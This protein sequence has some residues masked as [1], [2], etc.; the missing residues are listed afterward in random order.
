LEQGW[1]TPPQLRPP[2]QLHPLPC[3]R[4]AS[5]PIPRHRNQSRLPVPIS[6]RR[7]LLLHRQLRHRLLP[8]RLLLL[9]LLLLGLPLVLLP[10]H[11]LVLL[12]RHPL[13]LLPRHP[14]VL[15]PRHPLVLLPRH[16]PGFR[17]FDHESRSKRRHEN[18][19][20]TCGAPRP[21][22][23]T[24]TPSLSL[25]LPITSIRVPRDRRPNDRRRCGRPRRIRRPSRS[26]NR[27]CA[28]NRRLGRTEPT[29]TS[30][31]SGGN[32]DRREGLAQTERL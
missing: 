5:Q 12:P 25:S 28:S 7:R 10:R 21:P 26:C 4:L 29:T 9:R 32:R 19:P 18:R 30:N 8:H 16:P 24:P 1:A 20:C 23:L 31:G 11:P 22:R 15:L 17:R 6:A 2:R 13:V 14:L 3:R 27:M